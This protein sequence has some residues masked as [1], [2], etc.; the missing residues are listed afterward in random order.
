M[1]VAVVGEN[2]TL[3]G[4]HQKASDPPLLV[5]PPPITED[6]GTYIQ[7]S[8]TSEWLCRFVSGRRPATRPLGRHSHLQALDAAL[9]DTIA[10]GV[11][12]RQ[13]SQRAKKKMSELKNKVAARPREL[14]V[15]TRPDG[16]ETTTLKVFRRNGRFYAEFTETTLNWLFHFCAEEPRKPPKNKSPR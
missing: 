11:A 15:R 8:N 9:A 13:N 10:E 1:A 16:E 2:I 5:W 7:I 14:Q 3:R 6:G 12:V 4:P